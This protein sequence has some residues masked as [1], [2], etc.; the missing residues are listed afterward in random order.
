M[1]EK[2]ILA[3]V[4]FLIKAVPGY[5]VH[6][7][8]GRKPKDK[9]IDSGHDLA[10][11]QLPGEMENSQAAAIILGKAVERINKEVRDE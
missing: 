8:P 7:D 11:A 4:R 3:I 6:R 5:H 10:A 9:G 2:V 1:K